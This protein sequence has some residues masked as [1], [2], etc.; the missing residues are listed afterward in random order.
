LTL[1]DQPA[2]NPP[3]AGTRILVAED[4]P[5]IVL[6]LEFLLKSAGYD[7]AVARNGQ[8]ALR[9][10]ES[11]RPALLLLDVMLPAIDGFEV[12]R[13]LRAGGATREIRIL[14]LTARGRESEV[15]KGMAAGADAYMT[16]P[17]ATRELVEAVSRCLRPARAQ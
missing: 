11:W 12:C 2:G 14:M 4:E 5:N 6:S 8:E 10:A 15:Q 1:P 13:R 3:A 16:K 17:F 9:L 7:V